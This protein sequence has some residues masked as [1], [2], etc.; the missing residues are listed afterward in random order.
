MNQAGTAGDTPSPGWLQ[1]VVIGRNPRRTV[2][3]ILVLVPVVFLVFKFVL[4]PIRVQGISMLPTYQQNAIN[5]VNR[6]AYVF[7]EPQ[8]GDVVAI[9]F[10]DNHVMLMKRIIGMPGEEIAFHR[11]QAIINGQPLDE[12]YVR[13][14]C[15]WELP[16]EKI[17]LN[18]Y[19][20]VGDNRSMG[21]TEHTKGKAD[22]ERIVGKVLR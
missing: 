15:N 1:T 14:S 4:L 6:M 18:Q 7:H 2:I 3:R 8:R 9:R 5:C 20:V 16:P 21:Q 11:G 17:G 22:R 19:F 13:Y 12:P 10:A